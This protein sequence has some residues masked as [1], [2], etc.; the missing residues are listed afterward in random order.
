[1]FADSI[2]VH[3]YFP[4]LYLISCAIVLPANLSQGQPVSAA[5]DTASPAQAQAQA[6]VQQALAAELQAARNTSHPMRYRLR[7]SSPR[8]TT[9]K[10]IFETRDGDVACLLSIGDKPLN[11]ADE[12]Q[13]QARLDG[14]LADPVRQR[15]RKQQED[16]DIGRALRIL[17]ALPSAFEYQYEGPADTPSGKVERFIFRPNPNFTP[18]DLETQILTEMAGT[19]WIDPAQRRVTRLEGHLGRDVDFGWGILGRLDKGGWIIID[20]ADVGGGIWRITRFQMVMS[21]RVVF[22]NR[23]FDTIEQE[24][25]FTPVPAGLGYRQAIQMLRADPQGG[26]AKANS[27]GGFAGAGS[28]NA[29]RP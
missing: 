14:L 16:E 23:T 5:S 8:L 26:S 24:T 3:R 4:L 18:P 2:F 12:L 27:E 25:R 29:K 10:E 19:I 28:A 1:M 11:P 21:G 17:R 6:L 20:Q 22:K 9:T 15:H 7:K 13:E